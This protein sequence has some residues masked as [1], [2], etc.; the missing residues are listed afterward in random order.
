MPKISV[1]IPSYN[2]EKTIKK[3]I[4]SII[5]QNFPDV[6]IIC[7]D[8][9]SNDNTIS[10]LKEYQQK[11]N[12]IIKN[13]TGKGAGRSRNIGMDCASGEYLYFLDS[14]DFLA[15]NALNTMYSNIVKNDADILIFNYYQNNVSNNVIKNI[16]VSNNNISNNLF[17]AKD[18]PNDIL[19]DFKVLFG[20]NYL[21]H[22][23]LRKI[24]LDFKRFCE[25]MIYI[26]S[27]VQC[28]WL[29]RFII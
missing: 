20:I 28:F 25:L 7:V 10:I 8:D 18:I 15:E 6:E 5:N 29:K 17:N 2:A 22:L 1:I 12:I 23:L 16:Y 9:N 26:L 27:D 11:Y 21:K 14:D 3:C 4:D 19:C 24:I 13:S